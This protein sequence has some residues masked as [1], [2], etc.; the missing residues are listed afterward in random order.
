V[1]CRTSTNITASKLASGKECLR[2]R[3]AERVFAHLAGQAR[4][5]HNGDVGSLPGDEEIERPVPAANIE[6]TRCGRNK[7]GQLIRQDSYSTAEDKCL[8]RDP[9]IPATPN[10]PSHS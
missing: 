7:S 6:N 9:T 4:R 5:R 10:P 1:W 3:M 8:C 2:H